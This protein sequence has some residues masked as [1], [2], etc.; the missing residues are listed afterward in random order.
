MEQAQKLRPDVIIFDTR[1][2]VFGYDTNDTSQTQSVN[3]FLTSLRRAG[4]AVIVTHHAGKNGTQRGRTDGDD[5]LDLIIKLSPREGWKP[6]DGLQFKLD[7]EK[8][9]RGDRL[10]SLEAQ[11]VNGTW[12][13][14]KNDFYEKVL[15]R[16]YEGNGEATIADE[17]KTSRAKVRGVKVLAIERGIALPDAKRGRKTKA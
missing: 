5:P 6:G 7:Y 4:F 14:V 2:A 1:T 17:L 12:A 8:V 3:Q 11:Y 13:N 16:L 9:R 15:S 10:E